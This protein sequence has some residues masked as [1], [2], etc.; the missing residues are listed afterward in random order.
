MTF[1]LVLA[2]MLAV[3]IG[4]SL[5]M[6]G[7]GGAIVTL[8]VLVHVAGIPAPQA[9]G[10]S[11]AVVGGA[12]LVG[13]VFKYR[14]GHFHAQATLLFALTGMVGAYLGAGLTHL[15]APEVLM[16]L[17]ACLMLVV[18]AA[19]L[20]RRGEKHRPGVCRPVRCLAI[21]AAVG[22]LT[23][24]LG[25]GGGFL[26]VPALI[27]FAGVETDKAIGS[28]LAIVALNSLSGLA[29]QLRYTELNYG[30]TLAFLGVA[31]TGMLIGLA[32]SKRFPEPTLRKGF[33]WFIIAVASV[34][35]AT[36]IVTIM[37]TAGGP[38]RGSSLSG[39]Q[40]DN[41]PPSRRDCCKVHTQAG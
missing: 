30:L 6:L 39:S 20:R 11:M 29:G 37:G 14:L 35:L 24:F 8:P 18:A 2:L 1:G 22:L 31:L 15:L 34:I 13:A 40:S 26:I 25:V 23:G 36:T 7:S 17:F 16:L 32:I 41:Q 3:L 10:M 9:V 27:L 33:A 5:G 19:M 28:S 4:L 12:S 38:D 21:G